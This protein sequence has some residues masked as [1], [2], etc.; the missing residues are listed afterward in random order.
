MKDTIFDFLKSKT[1]WT[2]LT[3]QVIAIEPYLPMLK[4][5]LP[6]EFGY[7]ATLIL[8]VAILWA[9]ILRDKALIDTMTNKEKDIVKEAIKTKTKTEVKKK[10]TKKL[11]QL[12][13]NKEL[14]QGE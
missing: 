1:F 12:N 3:L 11:E 13:K 8:P 2:V 4:E 5:Y 9:K 7:V 10:V 14:E 6:V